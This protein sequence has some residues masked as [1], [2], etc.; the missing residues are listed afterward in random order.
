MGVGC[1]IKTNDGEVGIYSASGDAGTAG[2]AGSAGGPDFL[3]I[4]LDM[5]I[6]DFKHYN[7]ADPT[8][9]PDFHNSNI[10]SE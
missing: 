5:L 10:V 2:D 9:N 4:A 1:S 7:A 3:P 6:R 8:T